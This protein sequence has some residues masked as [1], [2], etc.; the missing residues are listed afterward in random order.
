MLVP[1]WTAKTPRIDS[2]PNHMLPFD[3]VPN[4]KGIKHDIIDVGVEY[5]LQAENKTKTLL[6]IS[7]IDANLAFIL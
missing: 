4:V 1:K 6:K 2:I 3:S 7:L 5:P